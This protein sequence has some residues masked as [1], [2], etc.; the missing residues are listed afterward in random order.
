MEH[1]G[2][3][4][5]NGTGLPSHLR[6]IKEAMNLSMNKLNALHSKLH[7]DLFY[8]KDEIAWGKLAAEDLTKIAAMFREVLLSLS[9]MSMLPDILEII[10][11][12]EIS[13][14]IKDRFD[15]E[16][17]SKRA[18]VQ[19]SVM[20]L[21]K[22]LSD[23]LHLSMAG[24]QYF[25]LTLEIKT[26]KSFKKKRKGKTG[27]SVAGDEESSGEYLNPLRTNFGTEYER[28]VQD[29]YNQQKNYPE[30]LSSVRAFG[31]PNGKFD[32]EF[33]TS[34]PDVR[35]DFFLLLYMGHMQRIL[36]NSIFELV[37]FADSKGK[38]GTMKCNRLIFP[39]EESSRSWFSLKTE[40][41]E[42]ESGTMEQQNRY[43]DNPSSKHEEHEISLSL[44]D[45][46]HLPPVNTWEKASNVLR[47]IPRIIRSELS[48]FGFRVAAASFCVAI[49]AF[50][51]QTQQFFFHGRCVWAMIVIVIGMT[52]TSGQTMF[53]FIARIIATSV[54]MVLSLIV[55][56]IVDE[57]TFG[58]IVFLYFANVFEYYFYVKKPQYFGPI[59]ISI[60]TLNVIVGYELQVRKL[61]LEVATSNDQPY[62]PIYIFGPYKLAAVVAG[63]AIS[64]FWVIFPY[65]I[66]AKSKLRKLLGHGL[67][68]LAQFYGAMH[69]TIEIWMS[70]GLSDARNNSAN[71]SLGLSA[72]R[73]K[74]FKE[75]MRLLN[76][77]RMH[78]HFT[79]YEPP[80]GGKFPRET[81]DSII[82]KTQRLLTSMSLMVSTTRNLERLYPSKKSELSTS[83]TAATGASDEQ[84]IS[85]LAKIAFKSPG[86][87][88]HA[89][90]SLL[91]HLSAAIMNG[92]PLPPY[93]RT[94]DTFPLAR[95]MQK[96]D[97]GLLNIRH[98]QDPAFSA[99][100]SLEVLRHDKYRDVKTLVGEL[101]FGFDVEQPESALLLSDEA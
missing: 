53:G 96:I 84:W 61:G 15:D 93:M 70:S 56:Y 88:S 49:L 33:L 1:T 32:A 101:S 100:V 68:I 71:A 99:F 62:Y 11:Q 21:H 60:V 87:R 7:S 43:H 76:T 92:Q 77:L 19:K 58:I 17:S 69:E 55:W 86:F 2:N 91:C 20:M 3:G 80:I 64:F 45:P 10:V 31:E 28:V 73:R 5:A 6:E 24:M 51:R 29:L 47:Y 66:T 18:E 90:S 23:T 36:L 82:F 65:P 41:K 40:Q 57:K 35:Q 95:Q 97:R 63:C 13:G 52:P 54:S 22:H 44:P 39:K 83:S 8:S 34:H 46:E 85:H 72:I 75:E 74:L 42:S 94:P 30:E 79:R 4:N 89:T 25:L 48:V 14:E 78:S 27:N 59:V 50:L 98:V 67:F 12:E 26:P 38:D 9:G 81:Y 16:T 37:M